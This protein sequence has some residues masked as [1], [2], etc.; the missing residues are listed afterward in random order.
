MSRTGRSPSF[1]LLHMLDVVPGVFEDHLLPAL[2]SQ[3]KAALAGTCSRLR[4]TVQHSAQ[5]LKLLTGNCCLVHCTA[6]ATDLPRLKQLIIK[7]GNL[8][9]AM[10]VVPLFLMKV[11]CCAVARCR[12]PF[13]CGQVELFQ[14]QLA[15]PCL[16]P[17]CRLD[18]LVACCLCRMQQG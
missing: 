15:V 14:V 5:V 16:Q 9:E 3:H 1:P 10:F 4:R 8:H 13:S 12:S 17:C 7:P 6:V 18:Q 11:G 2:Q